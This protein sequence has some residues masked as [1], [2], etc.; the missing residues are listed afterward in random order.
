MDN[1]LQRT[2]TLWPLVLFGVGYI[3]PIIVLGTF[4]ILAQASGGHVPMSYLVAMAAMFLTALSYANMAKAYPNSGSS[5]TYVR[6]TM[7]ACLGFMT[8]W[9]IL[10]D[11]LFLPMV[12]WLI[13]SAY[14]SSAFPQTPGFIWLLAFIG[15]TSAINIIGLKLAATVNILLLLIEM[16]VLLAFLVLCLHYSLGDS[17]QSFFSLKPFFS[18]DIQWSMIMGG[19]AIACYSYIGFDAVSTLSEE[20]HNPEKTIPRAILWVTIICGL[21]F[22]ATAYIVQIA[23]PSLSFDNADAA[24]YEIAL[25]I[26]GDIFVS[27]FLIG[28]VVGQFVSGI[29]AQTSGS[30]LLYV[31]GRDSVLPK[32]FFGWLSP[33]FGTPMLC[34][35]LMGLIALFAL[36]MD[37][38]T[39]TSFINFGAFLTF[40]MVNLSVIAHYWIRLK[41][42]TVAATL[43]F[44]CCPLAGV[45]ADIWLMI[46][47][48]NHALILG[49][50]W[51]VAGFLWLFYL[52][53]GLRHEPPELSL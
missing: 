50:C 46:S 52:T 14:L 45:L 13:G 5:Y 18:A 42:R 36:F 30:R 39:S 17:S 12:I 53:G 4:G 6:K 21:I 44:L 34:I 16:L 19:A 24:A 37:V 40:I 41:K 10:L 8:G 32:A 29:A 20:T 3:T 47:L 33:R 27:I 51:L 43:L 28:L 31:M 22:C 2:L 11:Y 35:V 49:L 26:G 23:W 9:A 7:D 1:K 15:I 38:T 48:D 25:N